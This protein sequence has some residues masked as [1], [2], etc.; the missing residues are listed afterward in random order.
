MRSGGRLPGFD[1]EHHHVGRTTRQ[2]GGGRRVV[3]GCRP[4]PAGHAAVPPARRPHPGFPR[5]GAG[6]GRVD[7]R[8]VHA[9]AAVSGLRGRGL[10][11]SHRV[12]GADAHGSPQGSRLRLLRPRL[13]ARL[14]CRRGRRFP[15]QAIRT[16]AARGRQPRPGPDRGPAPQ[17]RRQAR[18]SGA[19]PQL[20]QRD[21]AHPRSGG[22][23]GLRPT[24]PIVHGRPDPR[25]QERL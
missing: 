20:R 18:G 22:D 10:R 6:D 7:R 19:V 17:P 8:G 21:A 3:G 12:D 1:E 9:G 2:A 4:D 24:V 11:D 16:R 25:R 14:Q 15:S 23:A 5:L 13:P